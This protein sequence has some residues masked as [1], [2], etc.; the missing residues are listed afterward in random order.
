VIRVLFWIL[1]LANVVLFA[2]IQWGASIWREPT[3]VQPALHEEK[4]RLLDAAQITLDEKS[5]A[6]DVVSAA[7]ASSSQLALL[8]MTAA[9][10][11][12]AVIKP[13]MPIC[14][15][16]GE[17]SD[18]ELRLATTALS[19]M[20]LSKNLSKRQVEHAIGYWVY[21]PPLKDKVAINKKI[22]NLKDDGISEFFIVQEPGAWR[23]AISLGVFKT[24]EAAQKFL[25]ML[26]A[27]GVRSARVGKRNS[28]IKLSIFIFS[29]VDAAISD[30]LA[31]LQKDFSGSELKNVQCALTR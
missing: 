21:I 13:I 7:N 31:L 25:N 12:P 24:E 28:K 16:W 23:N 10:S 11:T 18:A 6:H 14:L 19:G 3:M 30:K 26:R 8:N 5:T 1:L 20:E 15:E 4:M 29:Q 2:A 22:M 27:K 17:F 9:V